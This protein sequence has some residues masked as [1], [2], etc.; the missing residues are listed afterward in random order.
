MHRVVVALVVA[1]C[2]LAGVPSVATADDAT[3]G[4]Q[5]GFAPGSE[6]VWQSPADIA[7]DLD[8]M[9]AT[10]ARWLRVPLQWTSME[11][12]KGVYR[13]SAH[14][15][16]LGMALERGLQPIAVV[17]YT[18]AWARPAGCTTSQ[19]CPPARTRD[20]ADFLRAVVQRYARYGVT[21]YEIWNEPNLASFWKP[22]PDPARYAALLK[23]AAVAARAADPGVTILSGGL[24]PAVR[25]GNGKV[26]PQ[27]FVRALYAAGAQ[28]SFDG[29]GMH[30]Y[31]WPAAPLRAASWNA[32]Y[33][34]PQLHALMA[35]RGDGHK[36]IWMTE[37]GYSTGTW[38][39]ASSEADQAAHLTE[40]Y[41]SIASAPWAGPLLWFNHRDRGS[42][43]SNREHNFGLV[44]QG[45]RAKPALAAFTDAMRLPLHRPS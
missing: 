21:V 2:L 27:T 18:P 33:T 35:A 25:D 6:F 16:V 1:L 22:A 42:D 30:P 43:P 7:R 37:F 4:Q 23:D 5:A 12:A 8:A 45:G 3:V 10:G 32:F 11:P 29:L 36:K 41:R 24:S 13:W 39:Q 38:A 31:A 20:Y 40:A 28:R 14:D 15:R 9:A 44:T 26:T 19:F 17:A 34:L